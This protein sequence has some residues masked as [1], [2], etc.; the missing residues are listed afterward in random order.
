LIVPLITLI[1]VAVGACRDGPTSQPLEAS[2]DR[3]LCSGTDPTPSA[4]GVY[5]GAS[6][7]Y[8]CFAS[9]GS[10][11]VDA[12]G[13]GLEDLC[14]ETLAPTFAPEL[15]YYSGDDVRREPH[16]VP[17][18]TPNNT[19]VIGYLLSYY[20][21]LGAT[22]FYGPCQVTPTPPGC[23]G[24]NGD[25]EDIFL[26]VLYD[27]GTQH[28]VLA[29]A[30]YSQHDGYGI[31][32]QG[33]QGYPDL[34]YPSHPG[35]YPRAYVAEGKHANYAT[36]SE[37]DAGGFLW[38]DTCE[39]VNT[40]A[41]VETFGSGGSLNLGSRAVHSSGQDC[42]ASANPSFEWYGSGRLECYWT[43]QRFRGWV[44]TYVAGDDTDPYSPKLADNGF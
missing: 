29:R 6:D 37:C 2:I 18:V 38:S 21:D 40:A 44:P 26:T 3:N 4:P 31:Y 17:Q 22:P 39:D 24:H 14:E 13:D 10:T 33:N 32:E 15:Y 25:S 36:A 43:D 7:P 19:V 20:Y 42:M 41:R 28:W 8:E 34:V 9:W 1:P 35:A 5:L 11:G 27:F 23:G 16:W 30:L 12:D